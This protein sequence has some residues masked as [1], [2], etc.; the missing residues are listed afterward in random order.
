MGEKNSKVYFGRNKQTEKCTVSQKILKLSGRR[1]T[2]CLHMQQECRRADESKETQWE[3]KEE[4]R[5]MNVSVRDS[6]S[7]FVL[8]K[9]YDQPVMLDSIKFFIGN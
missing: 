9:Y 5:E 1:E 6:V 4:S 7:R 3:E 2:D 8:I